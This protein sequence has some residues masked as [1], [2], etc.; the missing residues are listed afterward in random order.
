MHKRTQKAIT[1][2]FIII[3]L[4]LFTLPRCY[5]TRVCRE[6]TALTAEAEAKA[7]SGLDTGDVLLRLQCVYREN[8]GKLKLFLD[9]VSV[10]AAGAAIA[11][12]TPLSEPDALVPA[13]H[14]VNAAL[15]HLLGIE[16]LT[17]ENLF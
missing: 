4:L 17:V 13:L 5:L 14:T 9:H 7:I 10:D 11:A 12:C 16:S 3:L 6:M 2:G 15:Q 1:L 8:S